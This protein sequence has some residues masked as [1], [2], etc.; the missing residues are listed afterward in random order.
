MP[1]LS[2]PFF[3]G[4]WLSSDLYIW[5]NSFSREFLWTIIA[6]VP[7]GEVNP[8]YREWWEWLMSPGAYNKLKNPDHFQPKTIMNPA[9]V[10]PR[11]TWKYQVRLPGFMFSDVPMSKS[12]TVPAC[13]AVSK[14]WILR[15]TQAVTGL[16]ATTGN[17]LLVGGFNPSAK[18]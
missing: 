11:K 13:N 1:R 9:R 3:A 5:N 7:G 18:Y 4:Q 2:T 16:E 17:G 14:N 10:Y 15:R 6:T 12:G 8:K